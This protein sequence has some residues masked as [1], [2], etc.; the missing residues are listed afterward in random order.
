MIFLVTSSEFLPY[1][2]MPALRNTPRL[3][4]AF[5][6]SDLWA[7]NA[8]AFPSFTLPFLVCLLFLVVLGNIVTMTFTMWSNFSPL[9]SQPSLQCYADV[10]PPGRL[11]KGSLTSRHKTCHEP[12]QLAHLNTFGAKT[13]HVACAATVHSYCSQESSVGNL[14]ETPETKQNGAHKRG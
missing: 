5:L 6:H 3:L 4:A 2:V 10:N 13:T 8:L 9:Q 14:H 7:W 1:W 11:T 12:L